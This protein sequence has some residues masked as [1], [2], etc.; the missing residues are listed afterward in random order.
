MEKSILII[1]AGMAGLATGCYGR[2]NG[3]RTLIFE[4]HTSPGGVCT[5]WKRKGY[6]IDGCIH[7]LTGSRTGQPFHF[8]WDELGVARHNPI[9]D[10][11]EYARIEGSGGG[12]F[13]V[14]TD[15]DRLERHMRELAPEDSGLIGEFAEGIRDCIGFRIPAEKAP[16]LYGPGDGIKVMATMLPFLKVVRKW[17][18]VSIYD[19]A[20]RFKN[21][22]LR[23][24]FPLSVNLQHPR[25]F[26]MLAF[27]MSLSWMTQKNAG[28]PLG[29]SL[30]LAKTVEQRYLSLGG[31]I[32]YT[33]RVEKIMVENNRAV[34]VRLADGSEHRGDVVVSAADGHGTIF[35][36]LDEKF[37]NAKI[38]N[39]YNNLPLYNPLVYIGLGVSRTFETM[40]STVTGIDIP[41][42][43]PISVN[44]E[45]R[46]RLSMQMY[47]FDPGLAPV[48]KTLI[49]AWFSSDYAFWKE[50]SRDSGRYTAEKERIADQVIASLDRRFP[51]LAAKVEMRD[52]ATPI[53]FE[54]YTGNWRG[55]FEGWRISPKT[56]MMRMGKTLP[57]LKN[58]Y[59]AGQWVEPGGSLPTSAMSG[60]NAIQIICR[61]DRKAFHTTVS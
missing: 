12:T 28:Y 39:N 38:R 14:Y 45:E 16:E 46:T 50:L 44:G 43:R 8:L 48:G 40:P 2:M 24:V 1:G 20:V 55:S 15:V 30:E 36:M 29:G 41:L 27:L 13:I 22:F 37:I 11:E 57:G 25:D 32:R 17:G 58:F 21:P 6:T 61:A 9:I 53:T 59:M 19:F 56:L 4:M 18:K 54:R 35:D 34:G 26:P 60:R 31:E 5:S 33:S 49:R 47:Q 7:W 51:G 42:D 23:E 3:Y 52:M 10:H